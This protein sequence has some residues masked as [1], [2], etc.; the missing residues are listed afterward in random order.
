MW[1]SKSELTNLEDLNAGFAKKTYR[2][3]F[4]APSLQ[5]ILH[6][7]ARPNHDL[8]E[9]ESAADWI[10]GPSGLDIF[11]RNN[12]FLLALGICVPKI[13][14][15]DNSRSVCDH[16]FAWVEYIEAKSFY[17]Y[18]QNRAAEVSNA[19]L[20][21]IDLQLSIL[22]ARQSLHPGLPFDERMP[23]TSC[24]QMVLEN[25]LLGLDLAAEYNARIKKNK[26]QVQDVIR[27]L[28]DTI[29]PRSSFHLIHGE[30][31]PEH[32]LINQAE[33]VY[34]IDYEGLKFFDL[35][36]EHSLLKARFGR[37]YA[38]LP[39]P[40]LDPKRMKYYS[41]THF[42]GWNAFAAEAVTTDSIDRTWAQGIMDSST[43]EILKI[44]SA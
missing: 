19:L 29:K 17:D 15:A 37:D 40:D 4:K 32:I 30:C 25:A 33:A 28:V 20:K 44:V 43:R 41:L 23:A 31:S 24:E 6:I 11:K 5:C 34:F 22:H 9:V 10:L 27:N 13:F 26:Y 39:Q 14:I 36:F 16:D 35:E 7:W 8:T 42:V 3:T 2:L 18:T 21:K 12:E 1:G 38:Q